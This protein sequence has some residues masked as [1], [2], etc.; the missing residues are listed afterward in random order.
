MST[1]AGADAP[2]T[3]PA[4]RIAS[5]AE[6]LDRVHRTLGPVDVVVE[7]WGRHKTS[8][9]LHVVTRGGEQVVV[10]WHRDDAPYRRES[11]SLQQYA[12]ALGGDAPRIVT[13]DDGLRLLVLSRLLGEPA[14]GT[15]HESDPD[16]HYRL[17]E[18][19]RKLHDAEPPRRHDRFGRLIAAEF[20]RWSLEAERVF[21]VGDD[22][23]D[24]R[25]WRLADERHLARQYVAAALDLGVFDHVPAHRA[26]RPE[27][28][29]IDPGGHV[30]L[31]DFSQAEHEP[32]IVDLLWLEYGPWRDAPWLRAAF[33]HGY[34]RTPTD[35]DTA[36]LNAVAAT[37]GLELLVRG[38]RTRNAAE[39]RLGRAML[40]RLLGATLF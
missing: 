34:G 31:I 35:R 5:D 29:I 21:G 9:V 10:K 15:P 23:A 13:L 1:L 20:E 3:R 19:V 14:A 39:K 11:E 2:E 36:A 16:I 8:R 18:L 38:T 7:H 33:L 22:P 12:V 32:R 30:R 37:R 25:A 27:H 17:G 40:D 6:V 26:L 28:W 24:E 4:A